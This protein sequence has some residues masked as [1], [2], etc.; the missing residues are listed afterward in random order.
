MKPIQVFMRHCYYS[1]NSALPNR[2]RP[3]WFDKVKLFENFKRTINL[4]LADYTIIYDEKFG[5][6]SDTFL[7]NE[8]NVEVINCGYEAGSFSRTVDIALSKNFSDDTIIYFLEDDYLHQPKW[9]EI[10]LEGFTLPTHYISLYDHL[11]KYIDSGYDNLVSK[12][13]VSKSVHWRTTPS[14]CNTY[15]AK[16]STLWEDYSIHKHYS[17]ASPD[18]VSM[19]HAKF[20]YLGNIGKRLITSIPG[21]A[22]H[23]D[24]LQSPIVDW[25]QYL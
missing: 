12:I 16:V 9:C 23:C 21:Y 15:A 17:D 14:T 20:V 18:G 1:P 19:D 3:E 24:H 6:I 4:E 22:T 5:S 13:L 2:H 25:K 8:E 10:L 11:D 7:K